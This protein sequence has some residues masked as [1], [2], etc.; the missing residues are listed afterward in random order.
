MVDFD[1]DCNVRDNLFHMFSLT[2]PALFFAV[3]IS[4]HL[5]LGN[6]G[7]LAEH[8]IFLLTSSDW[9]TFLVFFVDFILNTVFAFSMI[10]GDVVT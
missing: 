7:R 2:S 9:A 10:T 6:A 1:G 4:L 8:S 3:S 5:M